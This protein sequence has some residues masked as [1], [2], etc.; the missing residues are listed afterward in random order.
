MSAR[1]SGSRLTY[2]SCPAVRKLAPHWPQLP[3]ETL[4]KTYIREANDVV[5]LSTRQM[6]PRKK[7]NCQEEVGCFVV[8]VALSALESEVALLL[9]LM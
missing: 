2:E 9:S 5:K 4:C 3:G 7:R 8:C 1:A 6:S